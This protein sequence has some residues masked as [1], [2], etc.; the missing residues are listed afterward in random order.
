MGLLYLENELSD[1]GF[2]NAIKRFFRGD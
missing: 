2:K 1:R